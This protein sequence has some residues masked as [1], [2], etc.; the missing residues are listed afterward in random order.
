MTLVQGRGHR[1]CLAQRPSP[2]PSGKQEAAIQAWGSASL[3]ISMAPSPGAALAGGE[4]TDLAVSVPS[5]ELW[6]PPSPVPPSSL[7]SDSLGGQELTQQPP[8]TCS[9][10]QRG[11]GEGTKD[12]GQEVWAS[13]RG[14]R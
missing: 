11:K 1:A 10:G 2:V 5:P 13:G 4:L 14:G 9:T 3:N 12:R 8:Q 6:G 7:R